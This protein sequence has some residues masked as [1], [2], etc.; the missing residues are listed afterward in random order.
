MRKYGLDSEA[1]DTRS[2]VWSCGEDDSLIARVISQPKPA[3]VPPCD[4]IDHRIDHAI[5]RPSTVVSSADNQMDY[6]HGSSVTRICELCEGLAQQP[7][8]M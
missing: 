5:I 2:V 7:L 4:F 8:C 6:I 3:K 1:R